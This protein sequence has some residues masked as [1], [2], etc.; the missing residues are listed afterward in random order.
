MGGPDRLL[1]DVEQGY[2]DTAQETVY[3]FDDA[4]INAGGLLE[5]VTVELL[6]LEATELTRQI[7]NPPEY[8]ADDYAVFNSLYLREVIK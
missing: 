7:S 2:G 4:A 1:V 5:F 8:D 6:D 3:F